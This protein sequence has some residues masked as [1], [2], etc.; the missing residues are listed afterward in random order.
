MECKRPRRRMIASCLAGCVLVV[1]AAAAQAQSSLAESDQLYRQGL[2]LYEQ[3]RYREAESVLQR[4]LEQRERIGGA[5]HPAVAQSL[6]TLG[7]VQVAQGRLSEAEPL[8]R[9]AL[10]MRERAYGPEHRSVASVL[11]NLAG[12]YYYQGRFTEAESILLRTSR[13]WEKEL[14]PESRDLAVTLTGLGSVYKEQGRYAEAESAHRRALAMKEKVVGPESIEVAASLN[15]LGALYDDLDRL[16]DAA[17]VYRRALAIK[18]KA[19]GTEHPDVAVSLDNLAVLF[20]RQRRYA[21]AEKLG[22]RALAIREKAFGPESTLVAASLSNLAGAYVGLGRPA[23]AEPLHRRAMAIR[24][25]A[26]GPDHHALSPTLLGL[27]DLHA[28]QARY[29]DAEALVRRAAAIDEKTVGQDHPY[30]AR[31]HMALAALAFLQNRDDDAL[32]AMRRVAAIY[33]AR[34]AAVDD[35]ATAGAGGDMRFADDSLALLA[36]LADRSPDRA[37]RAAIGAEAFEAAQLAG[38]SGASAA[39]ARMAA[40]FASGSDRLAAAV[41][42]RQD[43]IERRRALDRKLIAAL[44]QPPES[45]DTKAEQRLREEGAEL[46]RIVERFDATLTRDFPRYAEIAVPQPLSLKGAQALLGADEAMLVYQTGVDW[47]FDKSDVSFL[48]VL[49]RD[50]AELFKLPI[51]RTGLEEAVV[52]IRA[53]LDLSLF[54]DG[55]PPPFALGP[56]HEL[57]RKIVAPASPLLKGARHLLIVPA[58]ALQ[59]LPFGV[60]LTEPRPSGG[61]ATAPAKWLIRQYAITILPSVASLRALRRFAHGDGRAREPFAGFGD[62]ALEGRPGDRKGLKSARLYRGTIADADAVRALEPLP[63]TGAEL[64]AMARALGAGDDTL[65]LRAQATESK[66][67]G[68]DLSSYRVVAFATHGL[69][70]G[71]FRDYGEPA[72]VMTPPRQAT[73]QDDGLLGASEVAQ[74]KLNADWVILSACNTAAPD[75]APGAE[76]LSGL[77]KAFF[78]AGARSLLVSHWPVE[79]HSSARLTTGAID[80]LAKE[81]GIGRAE[82]MRRSMLALMADSR[83]AHPSYWGPF[84]VVGE[85]GAAPGTPS[86]A[87]AP[88]SAADPSPPRPPSASTA[89]PPSPSPPPAGTTAPTQVPDAQIAAAAPPASAGSAPPTAPDADGRQQIFRTCMAQLREQPDLAAESEAD[90][91]HRCEAIGPVFPLLLLSGAYPTRAKRESDIKACIDSARADPAFRSGS[92]ESLSRQCEAKVTAKELQ[93]RDPKNSPL[94]MLLTRRGAAGGATGTPAVPEILKQ[95]LQGKQP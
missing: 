81:P 41:R 86:A 31:S 46:D 2:A 69:M 1:A 72:L 53:T 80:A 93:A 48:W 6:V 64:R 18:E 43:A 8:F 42:E 56:S 9:R 57:Y 74:L 95:L 40:R 16:D 85:G 90:L 50:R 77:A 20:S 7:V 11:D 10:A 22:R 5:Q 89:S 14:G 60:L 44:G 70:A 21:D 32:A 15:N 29:A 17:S 88:T 62:P 19:L 12:L 47:V 68:T 58:G 33:R 71:Q 35:R 28:G 87:R 51:G 82:A 55:R 67:K 4:A 61:N 23:D 49:R 26:L 39:L 37:R 73:E 3:G 84:V 24:E 36:L 34:S 75:G 30:V 25:K 94:V 76:G 59:S 65:W 63:E 27:A 91:Q 92:Q 66:A 78:H 52:A 83:Y 54:T 79:S 13:I 45:R 38:R